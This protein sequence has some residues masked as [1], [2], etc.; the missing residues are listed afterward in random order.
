MAAAHVLTVDLADSREKEM[1]LTNSRLRSVIREAIS[2][3][4]EYGRMN[5]APPAD[6]NWRRFS[7][8]LDIG[9]LDLDKM[10]YLLGFRDFQDMDISIS[11]KALAE[12]DPEEFV[13]ATQDSSIA[14]SRMGPNEIL[15]LVGTSK[16]V[17]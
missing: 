5:N 16:R 12:R 6:S 8:A 1:K 11:P 4:S 2:M 9:V 3:M 13:A 14:G 10:A 17:Y 15:E 7:D